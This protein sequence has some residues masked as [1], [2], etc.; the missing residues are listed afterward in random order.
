MMCSF[1]I[2]PSLCARL[3]VLSRGMLSFRSLEKAKDVSH[4]RLDRERIQM[5]SSTLLEL[6]RLTHLYLQYNRLED[7]SVL[8]GC[9]NL[10]FLTVANNFLNQV[11]G[12]AAMKQLL[13]LD[14]AYN[15]LDDADQLVGASII[16]NRITSHSAYHTRMPI[17]HPYV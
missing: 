11:K 13:F 6:P 12:L 8:A 5:L 9:P 7:I 16:C 15:L 2:F 1:G 14:V 17:A 4:A 10:R 3:T